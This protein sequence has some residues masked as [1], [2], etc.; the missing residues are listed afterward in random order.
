[1]K[2]SKF[3]AQNIKC[4]KEVEVSFETEASETRNSK[5]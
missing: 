3:K 4:F 2:I 1:M 5:I